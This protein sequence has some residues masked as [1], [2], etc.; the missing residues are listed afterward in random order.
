MSAERTARMPL[1]WN[2]SGRSRTSQPSQNGQWNT[3][4]PHIA[5]I[6]GNGGGS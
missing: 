6:P 4:R 5:S 3:E 1:P 2:A